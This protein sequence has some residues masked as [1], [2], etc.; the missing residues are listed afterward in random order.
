[1]EMERLQGRIEELER[2]SAKL[3]L[4]VDN[5]LDGMFLH[6]ECSLIIDVNQRACQML[7]SSRQEL[8]GLHPSSFDP[9]ATPEMMA[10]LKAK[11]E[12]G[13]SVA[14]ESVHRRKDGSEYPVE[15][16]VRP[17][18][19]D[20][21]LHSLSLAQDITGRKTS[22]SL[23]ERHQLFLSQSQKLAGLGCFDWDL[24]TGQLWW[25]EVLYSIF[26][27]DPA[28]FEPSLEGFVER[29]H[30]D[31]REILNRKIQAAI[32]TCGSFSVEERVLR[33]DG[34]LRF[35][36]SR[37]QVV[38][39]AAGRPHRVMGVCL[40]VTEQKKVEQQLREAQK[41]EAIGR[42]AGGVAHDFNNI[43]SVIT[44]YA[45][46]LEGCVKSNELAEE[47]VASILE[48]GERATALTQQLLAFSRRSTATPKTLDLNQV[49]CDALRLL[50]RL[51]GQDVILSVRQHEG[52]LPVYLD[53]NQ[54]QQ[55]LMNLAINAR[56][57]MP[58]GGE[59]T[60][61]TGLHSDGWVRL[62][63]LDTGV[64]IAPSLRD[65]I[66]EPFF[67]TKGLS[68]GTGLGLAVVHGV[69]ERWGGRIL[70]ASEPGQGT[71]FTI[72]FPAVGNVPGPL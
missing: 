49:V 61:Q 40:D 48:A 14:F 64:G 20:G 11:L 4:F 33:P 65:K 7:G 59:L 37:G 47:A 15:V 39:N 18:Q 5:S 50:R 62:E 70:I 69:V 71:T 54:L 34:E 26:G 55:V 52:E 41:M 25:S 9:L 19:W 68:K 53:P 58:G 1:M 31:D 3:S 29:V 43:L 35:L 17:F 30:P 63:V 27:L 57:A 13:E 22:E 24:R 12:A 67:T 23:V 42:L 28:H 32:E 21:Q 16:R 36:E 60:I 44:G 66:F 10:S 2:E 6:D 56:D 72:D 45:E 46:L 51:I 38:C 8:I